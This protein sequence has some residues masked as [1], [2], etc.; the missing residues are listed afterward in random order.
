MESITKAAGNRCR[1]LYHPGGK[2]Y[3]VFHLF[4]LH[5]IGLIILLTIPIPLLKAQLD[6]GSNLPIIIINTGGQAI[7]DEPKIIADMWIVDN[8]PG[9][10]NYPTGPF[11]D[12]S[13][14]IGIE[15]RGS[16]SQSFPKKNYGIEIWDAAG[17]DTTASILGMPVEGDWVLHGPYSDKSLIRNI[18]AMSIGRDLGRYASRTRL[19]ELILNGQ[20]QG[21]YVAMEKIKRDKNRVS[22]AKLEPHENSGEDLTGG[23]ILKIDKFDGSNSGGGWASSYRPPLYRRNDQQIFFQ[24]EYPKGR[25]ITPQQASYI[26]TFITEFEDAMY[27]P[28]FDKL[29]G[30]WRDYL[31]EA[32]AIDY[33]IVQEITR[34]VDAYRLSTFLYKDRDNRD[35]KLYFGPIWD[36]NLAFGNADYC[37][38]GLPTGWAWDFNSYCPDD[39]WLIPF[40]WNRFLQDE[41]FVANLKSRWHSLRQ[42]PYSNTAINARIDSLTVLLDEAKD[43]NFAKWPVLNQYIWPNNYVGGSYANEIDYLKSWVSSRLEWLDT[44]IM[45][46]QGVTGMEEVSTP[47]TIRIFPNPFGQELNIH[48]MEAEPGQYRIQCT[49][50]LGKVLSSTTRSVAQSGTQTIGLDQGTGL[51]ADL[52]PGVYLLQVHRDGRP[53]GVHKV[54]RQ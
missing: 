34:D 48:L 50:L 36:F 35:G 14:K 19:T 28:D 20:Y 47:G 52:P 8:G 3:K 44:N 29:R 32:S 46:L 26:R 24:Y 45:G 15:F 22:I 12:Y 25:N 4:R 13:G 42:G 37:Q 11:N 49:D 51:P 23:Y 43:R 7:V 27:G 17:R 16:S 21:V 30:G 1:S 2:S 33:L 18:L 54:I 41:M 39:F 40:W 38:G 10:R 53:L 5:W 9:N 31:D 6:G